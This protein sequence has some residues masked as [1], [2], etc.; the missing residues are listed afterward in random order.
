MAAESKG[1]RDFGRLPRVA[2]V[3]LVVAL[4]DLLVWR[5]A[6]G[7]IAFA[8]V[9]TIIA[10]AALIRRRPGWPISMG[11]WLSAGTCTALLSFMFGVAVDQANERAARDLAAKV[12]AYKAERGAY[13]TQEAGNEWKG[14]VL[15]YTQRY[16]L[17]GEGEARI[18]FV[19]FNHRLQ[20]VSVASGQLEPERDQ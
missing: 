5:A 17:T 10:V 14:S 19:R 9:C 7:G 12:A 18:W 13:P 3:G 20:S 11:F 4:T 6:I 8:A 16:T 1:T 2:L 15:G